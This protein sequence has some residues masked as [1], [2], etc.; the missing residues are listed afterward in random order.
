M[1]TQVT[2]NNILVPSI[3]YNFHVW[4]HSQCI[5]I[6]SIQLEGLPSKEIILQ[7]VKRKRVYEVVALQDR[8][9]VVHNLDN[10]S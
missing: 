6:Q 2:H 3:Y 5:R 8:S 10:I 1:Y 4:Y 9:K 7:N